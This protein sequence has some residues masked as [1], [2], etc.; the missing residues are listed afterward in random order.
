M[1]I[2]LD[3]HILSLN[4]LLQSFLKIERY[5]RG[6]KKAIINNAYAE[7]VEYSR[8]STVTDQLTFFILG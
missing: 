1:L 2:R 4:Q 8:S 5:I 3:A 6:G 7:I